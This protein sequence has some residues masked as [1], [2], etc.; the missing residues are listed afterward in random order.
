MVNS[1]RT[2]S[3]AFFRL[4]LLETYGLSGVLYQPFNPP[5][6]SPC[7]YILYD[8]QRVD[9]PLASSTPVSTWSPSPFPSPYIF[10]VT[11]QSFT[12]ALPP[13]P[14]DDPNAL[15]S[16]KRQYGT[17][18]W[19]VYL[20][21]LSICKVS[22]TIY[23]F[24]S[25]QALRHGSPPLVVKNNVLAHG[26]GRPFSSPRL[27]FFCSESGFL[28]YPLFIVLPARQA[29]IIMQA[30]RLFGIHTYNSFMKLVPPHF[31]GSLLFYYRIEIFLLFSSIISSFFSL[32]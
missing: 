29:S 27:H 25:I 17:I 7:A 21:P 19:D 15:R 28:F 24:T 20:W 13:P 14:R 31:L 2:T 26:P 6:F 4:V 12:I 22:C 32:F 1:F 5:Y 16:I 30:S 11:H 9:F 3:S 23:L 10:A 8:V 18:R